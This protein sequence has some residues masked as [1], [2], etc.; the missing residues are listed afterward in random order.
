LPPQ[1]TPLEQ[2]PPPLVPPV[3]TAPLP[4][5]PA[6]P[7]PPLLFVPPLLELPALPAAPPLPAAGLFMLE[8]QPA[9]ITPNVNA[10]TSRAERTFIERLPSSK[11]DS[12]DR[13]PA[14]RQ[15]ITNPRKLTS[16]ARI[17]LKTEL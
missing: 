8:L 1:G 9:A 10:N 13:F 11:I 16:L 17:R 15:R 4:E 7:T 14:T 6:V 2:D 3:V 5:L 12:C